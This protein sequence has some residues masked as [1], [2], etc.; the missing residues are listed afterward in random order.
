MKMNVAASLVSV[1]MVAVSTLLEA[2]AVIV[3]K[4]FRHLSLELNVLVS[5]QKKNGLIFVHEK[6]RIMKHYMKSIT[7]G[8]FAAI[9]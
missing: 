2:T 8:S 3:M 1:R 5:N 6:F 4:G 7:Q 9:H